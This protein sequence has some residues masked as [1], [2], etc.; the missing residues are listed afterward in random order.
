MMAICAAIQPPMP[1]PDDIHSGQAGSVDEP[2]VEDRLMR[3]GFQPVGPHGFAVAGM[4]RRVHL[5]IGDNA[6]WKRQPAFVPFNAVQH[7]ERPPLT[8]LQQV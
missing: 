7:Q 4:R 6:S 2:V 1:K 5:R 8:P 3:N